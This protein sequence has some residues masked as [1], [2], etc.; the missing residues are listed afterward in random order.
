M[1]GFIN[2]FLVGPELEEEAI[3]PLTPPS[4]TQLPKLFVYPLSFI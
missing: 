3:L 2:P 4:F 1:S